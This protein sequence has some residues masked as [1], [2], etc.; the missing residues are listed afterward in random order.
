MVKYGR[1][2]WSAEWEVAEQQA[3]EGYRKKFLALS[4]FTSLSVPAHMR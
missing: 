1:V 3:S 2:K 4:A